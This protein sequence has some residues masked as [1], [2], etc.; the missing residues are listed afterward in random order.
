MNVRP[1]PKCGSTK[2]VS[3]HGHDEFFCGKCEVLFDNDPDEGGPCHNNPAIAAQMKEEFQRRQKQRG[4][5]Q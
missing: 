3:K 4:S 1:C 2:S 5:R